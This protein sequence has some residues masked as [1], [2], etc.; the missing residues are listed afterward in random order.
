MFHDVGEHERLD[1]IAGTL[2]SAYVDRGDAP[3]AAPTPDRSG[4]STQ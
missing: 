4:L 3:A 2:M 1:E